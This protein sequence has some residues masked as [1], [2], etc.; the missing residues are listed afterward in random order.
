MGICVTLQPLLEQKLHSFN[1]NLKAMF[2]IVLSDCLTV[3]YVLQVKVLDNGSGIGLREQL[4]S[5]GLIIDI[6]HRPFTV[7]RS[8]YK[9]QRLFLCVHAVL[10]HPQSCIVTAGGGGWITL[11]SFACVCLYVHTHPQK[12]VCGKFWI[13]PATWSLFSLQNCQHPS[14]FSVQK[15]TTI[16][17]IFHGNV[18]FHMETKSAA[19]CQSCIGMKGQ[20]KFALLIKITPGD[21]FI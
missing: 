8:D 16:F 21:A 18:T 2:F 6:V 11:L 4:F 3:W 10:I 5:R 13:I 12:R 15:W 7:F 19:V 14:P 17:R 1:D 20:K 9:V